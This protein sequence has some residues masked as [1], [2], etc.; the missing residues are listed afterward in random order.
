MFIQPHQ[1]TVNLSLSFHL[2]TTTT[3]LSST[4]PGTAFQSVFWLIFD[5]Q[6]ASSDETQL[7]D[8]SPST[9]TRALGEHGR[10]FIANHKKKMLQRGAG[11]INMWCHSSSYLLV[12]FPTP[13]RTAT[14]MLLTI[15]LTK[16]FCTAVKDDEDSNT[17]DTV[18]LLGWPSRWWCCCL[19]VLCLDW[20][21]LLDVC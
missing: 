14:S 9:V 19:L 12:I 17:K 1:S 18:T 20:V 6:P 3:T 13:T 11:K 21:C 5:T 8:H 15:K 10:R 16:G 4:N 7:K 2:S